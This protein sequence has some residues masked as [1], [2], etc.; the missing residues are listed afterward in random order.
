MKSAMQRVLIVAATIGMFSFSSER[1]HAQVLPAPPVVQVQP[2]VH[3]PWAIF[4]CPGMILLSAAVAATKD[5]RELT[6]W[7]AYT[8]G[9][10]YWFGKPP[11]QYVRKFKH[12]WLIE[13]SARR[14]QVG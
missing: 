8:C 12:S 4:A 5:G 7:E 14:V 9:V 2:Y 10:L 11:K 1:A 13:P 6:Y 3:F